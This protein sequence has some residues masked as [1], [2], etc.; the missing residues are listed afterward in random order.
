MHIAFRADASPEIGSGH[1]MRCVT[2]ANALAGRGAMVT[3]LTRLGAAPL[4]ETVRAKG[5]AVRILSDDPP[6]S[7]PSPDGT[8]HDHWLPVAMARDAEQSA[9]ILGEIG[10]L[11]SL[12]VDHYALDHR[13]EKHL[14]PH[15][16]RI[17]VIDDLADRRHDCDILLDQNLVE[18]FETRYDG[19]VPAWCRKLLGPAYALIGQEFRAA[20]STLRRR[21]G[22]VR[23]ILVFLGGADPSNETSKALRAIEALRR[24]DIAVDVV[25]GAM[26]PHIDVVRAQIATMPNTTLH[27]QVPNMAELMVAADLAIAAGGSATWE[28]CC[29]GLPT[30][31]MALADNQ[32]DTLKKLEN[33]K[34]LEFIGNAVGTTEDQ[35]RSALD[36]MMSS[37]EWLRKQATIAD[38][39]TDG[40]GAIC[41]AL[42]LRPPLA[43]AHSQIFLRPLLGEDANNIFAWQNEPSSRKYSKNPRPP[44]LREHTAW[45]QQK[46]TQPTTLTLIVE[47]LDEAAGLIHLTPECA[48]NA[49]SSY[50]VSVLIGARRRNEGVAKAALVALSEIFSDTN[51]LAEIHKENIS[52][53]RVF[54]WRIPPR[55]QHYIRRRT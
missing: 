34:L 1:L 24:H 39:V 31:A 38:Q 54:K 25:L 35:L 8:A 12:V 55:R 50:I 3:F 19:L 17:L 21:D 16:G 15:A 9:A 28:R 33:L 29:V 30:I 10:P 5:Y 41:V 14:R 42:V 53:I 13:W 37:P 26:S 52:S 45:M 48:C 4:L 51:L 47:V 7:A 20:R 11:D 46:L 27:V 23:R 44:S 40:R 18:G 49:R 22:V 36:Q 43:N 32:V 2:L 6:K